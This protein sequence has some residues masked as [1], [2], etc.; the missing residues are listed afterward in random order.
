[1]DVGKALLVRRFNDMQQVIRVRILEDAAHPLPVLSRV[2]GCRSREPSVGAGA[3]FSGR[4]GPAGDPGTPRG[5]PPPSTPQRRR[6]RSR[7]YPRAGGRATKRHAGGIG[8]PAHTPSRGKGGEGSLSACSSN[9][10]ALDS[11]LWILGQKGRSPSPVRC[12]VVNRAHL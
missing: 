7:D 12:R 9:A 6:A 2:A 5:S 10:I 3:S 8:A 1:V 4:A 11:L